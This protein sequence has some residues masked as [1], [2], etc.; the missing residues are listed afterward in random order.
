MQLLRT[1]L[2]IVIVYYVVRL[3]LR[4]VVPALGY[5][6]RRSKTGGHNN[7]NNGKKPGQENRRNEALGEYID[8]EEVDDK[9]K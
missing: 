5:R 4:Y 8:F 2:I 7:V 6:N 3:I 1:I 9:N